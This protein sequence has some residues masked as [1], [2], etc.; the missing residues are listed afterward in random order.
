MEERKEEGMEGGREWWWRRRKGGI[1]RQGEGR[2]EK[3]KV[4]VYAAFLISIDI[5]VIDKKYKYTIFKN[6]LKES[7][8][9]IQLV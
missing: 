5:K 4:K 9:M 3:I 7:F 8:F 6:I 1:Y 2:R